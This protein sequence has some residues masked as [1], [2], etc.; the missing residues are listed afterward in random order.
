MKK[1][2][3]L[4]L[5]FTLLAG[6]S[7]KSPSDAAGAALPE[8]IDRLCDNVEVPAYEAT[9]LTPEDFEYFAFIPYADGL[10]GVQADALINSMP[11]SLVLVRSE[12]GDT[13][14]LAQQMLDN[15]DA[16]KWIC[17]A[18][19]VKQAAYTEHYAVLVMSSAETADGILAN[20]EAAV[21]DGAV[22]V[23][24]AVASDALAEGGLPTFG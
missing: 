13:A 21:N 17:V 23:L 5:I 19:D 10:T 4:L 16:R 12:N 2:I 18:A 1:L 9:E 24:D 14:A 7:G 6:C 20:F 15:A 8:I 11:H 22:T 3:P